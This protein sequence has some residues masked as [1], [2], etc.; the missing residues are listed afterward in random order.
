MANQ[1]DVSEPVVKT[2]KIR[3]PK[4]VR[5]PSCCQRQPFK[6]E[7]ENWKMLKDISLNKTKI[8]KV[9]QC[10]PNASTQTAVSTALP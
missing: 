1:N 9:Q 5:C 2:I 6:K 4:W 3:L 7:R 8:L 10:M